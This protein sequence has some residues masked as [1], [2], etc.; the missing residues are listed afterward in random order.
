MKKVR[1]RWAPTPAQVELVVDC[2]NAKMTLERA[3]EI[4][5]VKPRTIWLFGERIG[6]PFP[7]PVGRPRAPEAAASG[8]PSRHEEADHRSAGS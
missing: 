7:A 1:G 5:G 6:R 2:A 3:A 8:E 4:V